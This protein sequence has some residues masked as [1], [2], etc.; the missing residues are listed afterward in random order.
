MVPKMA[1]SSN[2]FDEFWRF[3]DECRDAIENGEDS[4]VGN[5]CET[6]DDCY[7]SYSTCETENWSASKV[8]KTTT[9]DFVKCEAECYGSKIDAVAMRFLKQDWNVS[10]TDDAGYVDAF[11][12]RMTDDHC[13]GDR[14]WEKGI[15]SPPGV[16]WTCDRQCQMD[17]ACNSWTLVDAYRA[18][19]RDHCEANGFTWHSVSLSDVLDGLKP[20]ICAKTQFARV[21]QLGNAVDAAVSSTNG[22]DDD[23]APQ[24]VN[25]NRF[26]WT[27]PSIPTPKKDN[28]VEGDDLEGAY[29]SCALRIRYNISTSDFPAWPDEAIP[30]N[31]QWTRNMVETS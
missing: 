31:H 7:C 17:N 4:D 5:A 13:I 24:G 28:Y 26:L 29:A 8:C 14:Q 25:A 15:N 20:P 30:D 18:Q 1:G 2:Q 27:V 19:H 16:R 12:A 10:A 3:R 21:N 6:A 23:G 9:E 22:G 11:V